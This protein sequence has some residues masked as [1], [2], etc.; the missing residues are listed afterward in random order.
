MKV[1]GARI[2]AN[3]PKYVS[4]QHMTSCYTSCCCCF[5]EI[6]F[7]LCCNLVV[8]FMVCTSRLYY[9]TVVSLLFVSQATGSDKLLCFP[10]CS[11]LLEEVIARTPK[12]L[13]NRIFTLGIT[14]TVPHLT[15][16]VFPAN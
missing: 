3:I 7:Y 5:C 4:A 8:C 15:F 14:K 6:P 13:N 2:S 9:F 16:P 11:L 1:V 12:W 10:G